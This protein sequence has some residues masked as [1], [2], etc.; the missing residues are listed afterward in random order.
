MKTAPY[1]TETADHRLLTGSRG[2][3][4][5][6]TPSEKPTFVQYLWHALWSYPIDSYVPGSASVLWLRALK[7]NLPSLISLRWGFCVC[8]LW[9]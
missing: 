6:V 9:T 5:A 7:N 4:L 1:R 2:K 3:V 8:F